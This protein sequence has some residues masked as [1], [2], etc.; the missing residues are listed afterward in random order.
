MAVG[1]GPGEPRCEAACTGPALSR[2]RTCQSSRLA[3]DALGL[4]GSLHGD[5][6]DALPRT[7][8]STSRIRSSA[9]GRSISS[10]ALGFST[11]LHPHRGAVGAAGLRALH[12]AG[13]EP[14]TL[15]P[16]D[17]ANARRRGSVEARSRRRSAPGRSAAGARLAAGRGSGPEADPA[18]AL[19]APALH[20]VFAPADARPPRLR[21]RHGEPGALRKARDARSP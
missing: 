16:A 13:N 1:S 20:R 6:G 21:A 19:Y 2:L 4:L 11:V 5:V 12:P 10:F 17:G 7:A 14:W 18:P 15:F 8:T 3:P 9:R